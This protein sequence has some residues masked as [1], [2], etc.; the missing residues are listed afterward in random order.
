MARIMSS[1]NRIF[2]KPEVPRSP[3]IIPPELLVPLPEPPEPIFLAEDEDLRPMSKKKPTFVDFDLDM[4]INNQVPHTPSEYAVGR[5]EDIKYIELWYCWKILCSRSYS[6]ISEY[7]SSFLFGT[8][9]HFAVLFNS[10]TI[11]VLLLGSFYLHWGVSL[12]FVVSHS[13][14]TH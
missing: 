9:H 11:A 1:I 14:C 2:N 12:I 6:D 4:P 10:F 3:S 13:T 5:M 7:V 8:L